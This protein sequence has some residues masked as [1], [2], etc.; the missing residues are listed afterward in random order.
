MICTTSYEEAVRE[1]S[2]S[3][4]KVQIVFQISS[5]LFKHFN[6]PLLKKCLP[7]AK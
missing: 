1:N 7:A 5:I 3:S 2:F 4:P 6:E